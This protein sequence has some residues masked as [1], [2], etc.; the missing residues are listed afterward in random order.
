MA[1]VKKKH[2]FKKSVAKAEVAASGAGETM[3]GK[4]KMKTAKDLMSSMYGKKKKA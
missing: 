3:V 1:E 4:K 2:K